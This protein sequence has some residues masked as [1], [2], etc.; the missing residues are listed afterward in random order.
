[1]YH[2]P[3]FEEAQSYTISFGAKLNMR[4]RKKKVNSSAQNDRLGVEIP[5]VVHH[6]LL[7]SSFSYLACLLGPHCWKSCMISS[8]FH[9]SKESYYFGF[10]LFERKIIQFLEKKRMVL[11]SWKW[12]L[13][14]NWQHKVPIMNALV[15]AVSYIN[16]QNLG[17]LKVHLTVTN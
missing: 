12:G 15:I 5:F 3:C 14:F 13:L 4:E 17:K 6:A 8:A 1:M 11:C 7:Y 10:P 2:T 16:S 9:F